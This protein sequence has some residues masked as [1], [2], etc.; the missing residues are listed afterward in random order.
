MTSP[1]APIASSPRVIR[2]FVSSTFRDMQAERDELVKQ[3]FPQLRKL[4]ESRGV[5]WG[6]VDLRWGVTD[7]QK[8][9]G[10]VL[11]IC[12]AEIRRCRPYFIGLLGERYGWV[13]E[14][15]SPPL[16]DE[17]RWLRAVP[18]KSV[19]ELE[20]LHGVL[21]NSAMA[22]HAFFYFRSPAYLE[23]VPR[24]QQFAFRES[25]T[26]DDIARFGAEE[27][28]RRSEERKRKLTALKE[29]IQASGLPVR[30]DYSNPRA[31]GELV[32]A[33]LTSVIDRVFPEGSTPDP[34]DREAAEH[35]AFAQSR[36]HVYIARPEY[37]ERLDAHSRR[38]GPPLVV[39]G[40]SGSGKSALLANWAILY[41]M[42]NPADLLVLHFIGATPASTDWAAMLR[43]ILDEFKRCFGLTL[44]VPDTPDAL[45]L[46]FA[47]AL[48][49]AAA[50]GRVVLILDALD[51]LDDRDGAPDLAWLPPEIPPNVRL[52][53]STLPG[54]PLDELK[55]RDWPMLHVEPLT[56]S[57]RTQLV[58][59][60]L[61]QY[62]K[63]LSAGRVE[64]LAAAPQTANPL[65]LRAL[66]EEL[67]LWHEHETLDGCIDHYLSAATVEELYQKILERYEQDYERDRPGLVRDAMS[68]LWAARR[69]L[70]EAE[71]LDLLG[72]DGEPLPRAHWSPLYLAAEQSLVN[73][74][75]LL[76]F[77]HEYLR[78]A[79]RDRYLGTEG[80]RRAAHL[81]VADYFRTRPLYL[82]S[83]AN[84]PGGAQGKLLNLRK[85]D[86]GAWQYFR[87]RS[88]EAL[89]DTLTEIPF[90]LAASELGRNDE[91]TSY[92]VVLNESYPLPDSYA[93]PLDLFSK[94]TDDADEL[95]RGLNAV[96]HLYERFGYLTEAT[97]LLKDA[98]AALEEADSYL[99]LMTATSYSNLGILLTRTGQLEEAERA[100]LTGLMITDRVCPTIAPSLRTLNNLVGF[101]VQ[102]GQIEKA[103]STCQRILAM[104]GAGSGG[105]SRAT[106]DTELASA[107]GAADAPLLKQERAA[108]LHSLSGILGRR[109]EWCEAIR[110]SEEAVGIATGGHGIA[111][112]ELA[113]YLYTLG[114][115]YSGGADY[116]KAE[117]TLDR[118]AHILGETSPFEDPIHQGLVAMQLIRTKLRL[119][120]TADVP[121]LLAELKTWVRRTK[122]L[123]DEDVISTLGS[124]AGDLGDMN[125]FE[126]A[127]EIYE[128]AIES[129]RRETGAPGDHLPTLL[130]NF[131]S[132][133]FKRGDY[134]AALR[135][136]NEALVSLHQTAACSDALAEQHLNLAVVHR[137]MG[138]N[139]E[140]RAAACQARDLIQ[141]GTSNPLLLGRVNNVLGDLSYQQNNW[142]E[143]EVAYREAVDAF[144][145][146]G[147][148]LGRVDHA[149]MH[150]ADLYEKFGRYADA[151]RCYRR[152]M[153]IRE[154]TLGGSDPRLAITMSNYALLLN[155]L[156]RQDEARSLHERALAIRKTALGERHEDVA[157]SLSFL[158]ITYLKMGDFAR[159]LS[160]CEQ[161]ADIFRETLGENHPKTVEL[162]QSVDLLRVMASQ[163]KGGW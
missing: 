37:F 42:A 109:H 155:E 117:A 30:K 15:I 43:R 81:R 161:A 130:N 8:S 135:C 35:D 28:A 50:K 85:V 138:H 68:L 108:A 163:G 52:I 116:A 63:S 75:G 64:R 62:T 114:A 55:K 40:E 58:N 33:D 133:Y 159:A 29:R 65:Y 107:I 129:A 73:R 6:E 44:E 23:L 132:L 89:R 154:A 148:A 99:S 141:T 147:Q 14:E 19:T 21:N 70:S 92:W 150:L 88:F 27:A 16:M 137:R 9:E 84:G 36:A 71:L 77:F 144:E 59:E 156:G 120:N 22:E 122:R 131:G 146:A 128:L 56:T 83:P 93:E 112:N 90:V 86:E 96:G 25:P 139:E 82:D 34:L 152:C 102:S 79:V 113:S 74:S 53:L 47:N 98:L 3:T 69:G 1:T 72:R 143:A 119:G 10:K 39:L 24:D 110:A 66:L 13:P 32:L 153:D 100:F 26:R 142:E 41:Q 91:L 160:H 20:I 157:R 7:E 111:P 54:R 12:L 121:S 4:C 60:Y 94:G 106:F 51:Q 31:L 11:P 162:S 38:S 123:S 158:G 67:R 118:A 145:E 95:S 134:E 78:Q 45:R 127:E 105:G 48:H 125:W 61:A 104:T 103:A 115:A 18:G 140:A 149:M 151:E 136:A 46:T 2:V 87:A 49:I 101:Y 17:E 76:G 97:N 5:T 57:E 80:A 124:L 126:E